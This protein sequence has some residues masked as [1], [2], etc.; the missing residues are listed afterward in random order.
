MRAVISRV[1]SASVTAGG[2]TTG[3]IG[4]G[5][6]VLL[7]VGREDTVKD[8]EWLADRV[9]KLRVFEDLSGKMNLS[10]AGAGAS[11]LVVP[12]FTLYGDCAKRRPSFSPAAPPDTAETLYGHFVAACRSFGLPVETGV[13][14]GDMKVASVG[15]GPVTLIIEN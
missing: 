3:Q 6:L 1:L 12:N 15:D 9:C 14:G 5:F 7:G 13:F 11:L 4:K 10:P 8:A 2:Q